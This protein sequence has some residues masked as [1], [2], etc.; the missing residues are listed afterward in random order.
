M[1]IRLLVLIIAFVTA[2]TPVAAGGSSGTE[3]GCV[4]GV[5]GCM[6]TPEQCATGRYNGHWDGGYAGRLAVCVGGGGHIVQYAGGDANLLC[7]AIIAADQLVAGRWTDPNRCPR[8]D[9][10][11]VQGGTGSLFREAVRSRRGVVASSSEL[12]SAIG[13]EIL[14][15][16]GNA[17]DAAVAT[18]FA[19]G[20]AR[21]DLAGIGGGGGLVYRAA[22]GEHAA[23]DFSPQWPAA[24]NEETFTPNGPLGGFGLMPPLTGRRAV[25]V[26]G[27]VAGLTMGQE[28]FGRL[29]LAD[30]IAPAERLAREGVVVS[31]WLANAYSLGGFCTGS[32]CT[33]TVAPGFGGVARL[34]LSPGSAETFLVAGAL[35]YRPGQRLVQRDLA[36]SLR[37]IARQG[38]DAFYRGAIAD[39]IEAELKR[40][41]VL[42][43][44]EP[45]M[46]RAD[47]EAYRPEW[48]APTVSTYRG[49]T[50][51][52][53]PPPSNSGVMTAEVL[54][55]I[56]A[57]DVAAMGHSSADYIH[58]FAEAGKLATADTEAYVADP[59]F[60]D[61]PLE[62]LIS[63]EWAA[64]RRA[65]ISMSEARDHAA[66][67]IGSSSPEAA[68]ASRE[69]GHTAHISVVDEVGNA[70]ALTFTVGVTF[71]SAVTVG[72]TGIL[73]NEWCCGNPG[74]NNRP[75][76]GKFSRHP[77]SPTIVVD[78]GMPIL[79]TGAAGGNRI[80]LAA[81][82]TVSNVVDFGMDIGRAVDA[83][84]AQERVCCELE[85]E[86]WRVQ[87]AVLDELETRGHTLVFGGEYEGVYGD[88]AP[89]RAQLAAIDPATGERLAASD[90]RNER[91]AAAQ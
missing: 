76:G 63:K 24:A 85:I 22:G 86:Q 70:A 4:V 79:V 32:V 14:N 37:E 83:A 6:P 28:R 39:R 56:E 53:M 46:T 25:G 9:R 33:A 16:G 69:P 26:P 89:T 59:R 77:M 65:E 43:G 44:D 78:D 7:G 72:G 90:P 61:V 41:A 67:A 80:P 84:R 50:I 3:T 42:P 71:G 82:M 34:R 87:Q 58:L 51:L 27:V 11:G 5:D 66:G 48:T 73:L 68:T 13:V 75:E 29:A 19:V 10:P 40:P 74:T 35:P 47:L 20:V 81:I 49:R 60:F 55:I 64:E 91:G 62:T 31:D 23:L 17:M 57:F 38:A 8:S 15:R 2:V 52:G 30:V 45:L 12:A 88:L 54:N 18:A 1:H 36:W 21:P